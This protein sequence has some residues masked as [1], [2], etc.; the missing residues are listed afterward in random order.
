MSAALVIDVAMSRHPMDMQ[1]LDISLLIVAAELAARMAP[2][3]TTWAEP[4]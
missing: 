3:V 1:S 4:R 2:R